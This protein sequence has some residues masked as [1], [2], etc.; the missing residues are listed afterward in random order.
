MPCS[1]FRV[2]ARY[3]HTLQHVSVVPAGN[4]GCVTCMQAARKRP[5]LANML[6]HPW[7]QLPSTSAVSAS[8]AAAQPPALSAPQPPPLL[9]PPGPMLTA[10]PSPP[11]PSPLGLTPTEPPGVQ[12]MSSHPEEGRPHP[13]GVSDL[14]TAS[15]ETSASIEPSIAHSDARLVMIRHQLSHMRATSSKPMLCLVIL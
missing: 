5:A 2:C 12:S 3:S 14:S 9:G 4:M 1:R 6:S 10:G 11:G 7:L 13:A 15:E 8:C